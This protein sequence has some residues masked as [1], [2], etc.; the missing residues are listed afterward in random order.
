MI[1]QISSDLKSADLTY[2]FLTFNLGNS[3]LGQ[4]GSIDVIS[5]NA[6]GGGG[7]LNEVVD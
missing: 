1:W 5:V 4:V 2:N 6:C 7:F 3:C